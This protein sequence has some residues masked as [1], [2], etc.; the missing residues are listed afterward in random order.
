MN[1]ANWTMVSVDT[2]VWIP[3]PSH[4]TSSGDSGDDRYQ[5]L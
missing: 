3:R 1:R 4:Q 2:F 5:G